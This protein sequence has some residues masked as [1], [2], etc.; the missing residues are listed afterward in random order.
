VSTRWDLVFEDKMPV[1][2]AGATVYWEISPLVGGRWHVLGDQAWHQQTEPADPG[3]VDDEADASK[4]DGAD[5][6]AGESGAHGEPV[7]F[8]PSLLSP[9]SFQDTTRWVVDSPSW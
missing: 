7:L 9:E 6:A 8:K 3:Q 2:L 1:D 4:L 5:P